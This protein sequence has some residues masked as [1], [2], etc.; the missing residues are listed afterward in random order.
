MLKISSHIMLIGILLLCLIW[1]QFYWIRNSSKL[2][3]EEFRHKMESVLGKVVNETEKSFYC[4]DIYTQSYSNQNDRY[5]LIKVDSSSKIDTLN[6]FRWKLRGSDTAF[7]YFPIEIP[8][9]A[10]VETE[11]RV[12]FYPDSITKNKKQQEYLEGITRNS[13]RKPLE[14]KERFINT[15]NHY[16]QKELNS[17]NLKDNFYY[18]VI[19]PEN[20]EIVIHSDPEQLSAKNSIVAETTIFTENY[21][22]NSYNVHLVAKG[23][24]WYFNKSFVIVIISSAI[25]IVLL[26]IVMFSLIRTTIQQQKL[27]EMKSDFISN[28]T[29]E[30]KTPVAN[31]SLALETMEKQGLTAN[32]SIALYTGIIREENKRLQNNIDLVLETSVLE[33]KVLKMTKTNIDIHDLLTGIIETKQ[34]EASQENGNIEL[35]LLAKD[36][37]IFVDEV[38]LSNAILN[39]LDNAIKYCD[40]NPLIKVSTANMG[41]EIIIRV[42]DNGKGIPSDS[43]ARIFEKFH[44][45]PDGNKHDVKGFGL[46]LYYVKQ[47]IEA[48]NGKIKVQSIMNKGSIFEIFIPLN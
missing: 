17:R 45:V 47:V 25:L 12:M 46:G 27:S 6:D 41:D 42:E 31:I 11:F 9:P 24:N 3:K 20:G 26:I 1:V 48:H 36:Y 34:I 8:A 7:S 32:E 40:A 21:F 5:Y 14:E 29:H 19:K 18:K 2:S 22:M 38:H 10:K 35:Y 16:L 23:V 13:F 28:M 37:E 43:L 30:F 44:R 33:S 15:F 39:L 4:I